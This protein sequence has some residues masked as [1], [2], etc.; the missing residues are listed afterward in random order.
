MKLYFGLILLTALFFVGCGAKESSAPTTPSESLL[1]YFEASQKAD[2]AKMK[3]LLSKGSLALIEQSAKAQNTTVDA[4]LQKESLVKIQNAPVT[5]NEKIEGDTATLELRNETNGEYDM[6]MPFVKED[7]IWKLA[8]DK[9]FE[10]VLK[11]ANEA[12]EKLV[13][14]IQNASN[15]NSNSSTNSNTVSNK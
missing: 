9:Y 11:K 2:I 15:A 4:L 7:G 14:D 1:Q 6:K 3:S 5:R 8:R 10:E 13:K 12:R